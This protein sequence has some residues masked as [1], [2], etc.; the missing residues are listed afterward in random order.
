MKKRLM[1]I[2]G[3]ACLSLTLSASAFASIY[4]FSFSGSFVGSLKKPVP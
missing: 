3:V 1:S 4:S 2:M